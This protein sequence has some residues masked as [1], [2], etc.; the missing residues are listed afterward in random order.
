T[1]GPAGRIGLG[2]GAGGGPGADGQHGGHLQTTCVTSPAQDACARSAPPSAAEDARV[3]A[4]W[5]VLAALSVAALFPYLLQVMPALRQAPV[6][7]G[8]LVPL[9]AVQGLVVM[10]LLAWLG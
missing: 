3:A 4:A 6:P 2:A 9:Q 1:A 8:L 7:L 5:A 10:G